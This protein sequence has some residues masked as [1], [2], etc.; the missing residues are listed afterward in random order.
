MRRVITCI[1]LLIFSIATMA[2]DYNNVIIKLQKSEYTIKD[3]FNKVEKQSSYRF[4]YADPATTLKQT[5][6]LIK[7][8]YGLKDLLD[9]IMPQ[10]KYKYKI[11]GKTI[12]LKR[13]KKIKVSGIVTDASTGE[14]LIGATVYIRDLMVGTTTNAYGYYTLIAYEGNYTAEISYIG[15]KKISEP[16]VLTEDIRADYNLEFSSIS[17]SEVLVT[18]KKENDNIV[19][20]TLGKQSI[21]TEYLKTF[22]SFGGEPDVLKTMQSLSGVNA[23]IPGTTQLSVHGGSFDQNLVLLD[24][25]PVYNPSHT[26]GF[27]SVFNPDVFKTSDIYKSY[28]PANYGGR[29]SSVIDIR[30]KDGNKEKIGVNGGIGLLSSKLT[31]E[32]PIG[33]NTTFVVAGRYSYVGAILNFMEENMSSVFKGLNE[34][35]NNSKINFY[36]FNVKLNHTINQNNRLYFSAY[37]GKDHFYY[38]DID[39]QSA[40]DWG[41]T[42]GT[43]RWN[44]IFSNNLFLNTSIIFSNYAYSYILK[45]DSQSFNW[46]AD[47]KEY[48][49]KLDFDYSAFANHNIKFGLET[50]THAI[51]PGKIS[52]RSESSNAIVK[53]LNNKSANTLAVYLNDEFRISDDLSANAGIRFSAIN[54]GDGGNNKTYYNAEP[55]LSIRYMLT[56]SSSVKASYTRTTQYMHLMSNSSL[57]LP[58]DIWLPSDEI[59]K[60]QSAN[61]YS[62]GI[63]KNFNDNMFMLSAEGYYKDMN[64]IID[65]IDNSNL[66]MN[67]DIHTQILTGKGKAYGVDI[68]FKKLRGK[69]SYQISYSYSRTLRTIPGINGGKEYAAS[70]DRPHNIKIAV[71]QRLFKKF[72]ASL[73]FSYASGGLYTVPSGTYLYKGI[74][75][76]NYT[77]RNGYRAPDFHSMDLLFSYEKKHKRFTSEF[78]LGIYNV[79]GR[80]N[81]FTLM[82]KPDE[83]NVNKMTGK[84]MYLFSTVPTFTYSFKF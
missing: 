54:S 10:I 2:Q 28:I 11:S 84:K 68:S 48:D 38:T 3:L 17:I 81:V 18:A 42:T 71:T 4:A 52:P 66:F 46:E 78:R 43:L 41:N 40:M 19:N 58:T 75:F 13:L 35:S 64:N 39:D 80:K 23:T 26:L 63:Y 12:T 8:R 77:E 20:N 45:D 82:I 37:R 62:L 32:G 67:E 16:I 1:S 6:R 22:A 60:P 69:T 49:V 9:E 30:T 72:K 21:N 73:N 14:T 34:L 24:E 15:Y 61:N 29:L 44:K 76:L 27:F 5:V 51:K 53:S 70:F 79:Y 31:V 50:N 57:G 36:D 59:I 56:N 55:R 65:F 83:Y 7:K 33:N 25:A 74:S 47:L